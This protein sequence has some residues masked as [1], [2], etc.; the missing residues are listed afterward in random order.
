MQRIGIHCKLFVGEVASLG[1]GSRLPLSPAPPVAPPPVPVA[2][3][4][5]RGPAPSWEPCRPTPLAAAVR[6]SPYTGDYRGVGWNSRGLLAYDMPV[7]GPKTAQLLKFA[8]QHDFTA[9]YETHGSD[10]AAAALTLPP[11]I[12]PFWSHLSRQQGGIALLLK[13]TFL[14]RFLPVGAHDWEELCEGRL[15]IL[16]L[17]GPEGGLAIIVAYMPSGTDQGVERKALVAKIGRWIETHPE[18]LCVLVGDFNFVMR[19]VDR[20]AADGT[21]SGARDAGE[22]EHWQQTIEARTP[23]RESWQPER[24]FHDAECD[25]RLDRAYTTHHAADFHQSTL[26][27]TRM[28]VARSTS[29]HDGLSFGR[30]T[31]LADS[32]YR[33]LSEAATRH[34]DWPLRVAREYHERRHEQLRTGLVPDALDDAATTK[35]AMHAVTKDMLQHGFG[36]EYYETPEA[37]ASSATAFRVI[38]AAERGLIQSTARLAAA[39]PPCWHSEL[40]LTVPRARFLGCLARLKD[41]AVQ[42]VK[43]E[44]LADLRLLSDHPDSNDVQQTEDRRNSVRNRLARLTRRTQTVSLQA[45]ATEDGEVTTNAQDMAQ[46]LLAHWARVFGSADS[47]PEALRNWFALAAK[48]NVP[49]VSQPASA[50]KV[51]RRDVARA[52]RL[53]GNSR[54]GPDGVPFAA[55]RR[56]GSLAANVLFNAFE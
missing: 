4:A 19:D 26:F 31:P 43:D 12:V 2:S 17:S 16:T 23:M 33:S 29:D 44:V 34:P 11:G 39:L 27:A 21:F 49:S 42:L 8:M 32:M 35:E 1:P 50:W 9:A 45:V 51:R 48:W 7:Q 14:D 6:F 47:D 54:P 30:R 41:K 3:T 40:R 56:L 22:A 10:G 53:A 46:A 55:W 5:D 20:A 15:G 52:L 36:R 24:T 38:A 18:K 28:P 25:S 37:P 13:Q